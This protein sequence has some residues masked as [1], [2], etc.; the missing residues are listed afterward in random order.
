MRNSVLLTYYPHRPRTQGNTD[1]AY[2]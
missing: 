1:V 2:C